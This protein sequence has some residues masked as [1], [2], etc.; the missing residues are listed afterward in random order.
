MKDRRA[1][2]GARDG[3]VLPSGLSSLTIRCRSLHVSLRV[4]GLFPACSGRLRSLFCHRSGRPMDRHGNAPSRRGIDSRAPRSHPL[5]SSGSILGAGPCFPTGVVVEPAPAD[6]S[7]ELLR[8]ATG[9]A[10]L[11]GSPALRAATDP[12]PQRGT[13][14]YGAARAAWGW[15]PRHPRRALGTHGAAPALPENSKRRFAS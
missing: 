14:L 8:P 5:L 2:R 9:A 15:N 11:E 13:L 4:L 10:G 7:A 6:G 12:W 1:R 3:A